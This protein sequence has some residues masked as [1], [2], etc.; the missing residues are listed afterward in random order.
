V[1]LGVDVARLDLTRRLVAASARTRGSPERH[2]FDCVG[3]AA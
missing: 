1:Q 3:E 2:R